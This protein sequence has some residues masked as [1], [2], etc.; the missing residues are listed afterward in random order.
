M[1]L[2]YGLPK[3]K[4]QSKFSTW[5]YKITYNASIAYVKRYKPKYVVNTTISNL[6]E[7]ISTNKADKNIMLK[8][9]KELVQQA[10]NQLKPKEKIVISLFYL[11]EQSIEEVAS[12]CNLKVND[13][14]VNLHRGRK[15]LQQLLANS[16]KNEY[17]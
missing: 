16:K 12:I 13:V 7:A 15:K 9:K 11:K 8:E 10:I 2:W 1:K 14:K 17:V 5:L 3:F 6:P 4:G